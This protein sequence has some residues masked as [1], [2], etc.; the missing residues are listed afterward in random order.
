MRKEEKDYRFW[1]AR[2]RI[3]E[4]LKYQRQS[5]LK[6]KAGV[7]TVQD[8]ENALYELVQIQADAMV[9]NYL[10]TWQ[11]KEEAP[12]HPYTDER[13]PTKEQVEREL[14]PEIA[15][16]YQPLAE[17]IEAD[18]WEE[19]WGL[20]K[21]VDLDLKA[22]WEKAQKVVDDFER[23]REYEVPPDEKTAQAMAK[24]KRAEDLEKMADEC[25]ANRAG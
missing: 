15:R 7:P 12:G 23:L 4:Y 8:L 5:K 10:A 24:L 21:Y 1:A 3:E 18:S 2:Y 9:Q 25:Q 17:E 14:G 13:P 11:V 16:G 6:V 19:A 20:D 22:R